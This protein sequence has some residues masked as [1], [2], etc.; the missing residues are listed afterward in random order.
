MHN[1]VHDCVGESML[2]PAK[3]PLHAAGYS[4]VAH[5]LDVLTAFPYAWLKADTHALPNG[6]GQL[7][8]KLAL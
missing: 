8:G 6:P 2:A 7:P 3:I 1:Y 5:E 4:K